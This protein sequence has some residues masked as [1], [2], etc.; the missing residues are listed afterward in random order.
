MTVSRPMKI[1][2]KCKKLKS[3][4]EFHIDNSKKDGR[5][6]ICK[7]CRKVNKRKLSNERKVF[8][9]NI[10]ASIYKSIKLRK[11]GRIWERVLGY[12]LKD[13]MEH[14]EKQFTPEMNWENYGSYWWIDKIIPRRAYIY[15]DIRNNELRKCWSLKNMRP[16]QRIDCIRKKDKIVWE[17]IEEYKLFDILPTSI[18]IIDKK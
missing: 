18:I 3:I 13:L 4:E 9:R 6:P 8:D 14:L 5:K 7:E 12:T 15:A 11:S 10:N 17:L 16:L 1:C 2:N